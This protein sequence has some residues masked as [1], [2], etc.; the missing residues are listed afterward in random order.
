M[1]YCCTPWSNQ[2]QKQILPKWLRH[3]KLDTTGLR[4]AVG[5]VKHGK[6]VLRW[7]SSLVWVVSQRLDS[8]IVSKRRRPTANWRC[9][10][11][12]KSRSL[13]CTVARGTV[14]TF[15]FDKR[16]QFPDW[17]LFAFSGSF[18]GVTWLSYGTRMIF[19]NGN[20]NC[21]QTA[22]I[23]TTRNFIKEQKSVRCNSPKQSHIL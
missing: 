21:W 20:T 10:T 15:G 17:V 6:E 1:N 23:G 19:G 2:F 16:A 11:S 5:S 8:S 22:S 9:E 3:F 18:R 13:K 12:N 14:A 7:R 4:M